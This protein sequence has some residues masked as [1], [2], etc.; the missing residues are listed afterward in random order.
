MGAALAGGDNAGAA[1]ADT[2]TAGAAAARTDVRANDSGDRPMGVGDFDRVGGTLRSMTGREGNSLEHLGQ[3]NA[4]AAA[5][6]PHS[7][8]G[9]KCSAAPQ[10]LQ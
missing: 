5:T 3:R 10:A 7:R 1:L 8:H 6:A 9:F 4:P 2:D